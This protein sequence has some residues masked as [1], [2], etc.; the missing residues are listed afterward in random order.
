MIP[1]DLA[2]RLG[3]IEAKVDGIG[4]GLEQ[5][6]GA[7]EDLTALVQ[8]VVEEVTLDPNAESPLH[9]LLKRMDASLGRIEAAVVKP[10]P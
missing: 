5:L 3:R 2:A 8:K 1:A 7:I 10:K 9:D 4:P 6:L